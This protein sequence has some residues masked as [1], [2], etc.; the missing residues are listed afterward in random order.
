[1]FFFALLLMVEHIG[2]AVETDRAELAFVR[3]FVGVNVVVLPQIGQGRKTFVRT[4]GTLVGL[5]VGGGVLRIHV[6][7]QLGLVT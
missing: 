2:L 6:D 1:M 5:Q 3:P 7:L 4:N